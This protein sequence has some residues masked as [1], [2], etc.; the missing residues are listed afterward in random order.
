[1]AAGC[2]GGGWL[3][4]RGS[5][6]FDLLAVDGGGVL[7]DLD[8]LGDLVLGEGG[9]IVVPALPDPGVDGA[10]EFDQGGRVRADQ[11]PA[12]VDL[13]AGAVGQPGPRYDTTHVLE[14]A[15]D[16]SRVWFITGAG[17]GFGRRFTETALAHGDRV[18][19][20]L[21]QPGLL[22]DLRA[23]YHGR[24]HTLTLDIRDRDAVFAAVATAVELTGRLDIVINN[25]G[26]VLAGA[27]E[28][29]T[30]EAARQI[31][32]TNFFG[33]LWVCQAVAPHLRAQRSGHILQMSSIAGLT[34]IP[35]QGLYAAGKFAIEG[36]TES[37]AGEL[38]PFGVHIT[39]IEPGAYATGPAGPTITFAD[40]TDAYQ[41]VRSALMER[42][43]DA[44]FGDP[45]RVAEAILAVVN[46]A[47]PPRRLLLGREFDMIIDLYRSRL[48]EWTAW[49][50]TSR[51]AA[52]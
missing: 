22:D 21:R 8:G 36:M 13:I 23:R 38:E 49:E 47:D 46:S 31:M 24:L 41:P 10:D 4:C 1:M 26:Y 17:R 29:I 45:A 9:Q 19:A 50:Q 30:E 2:P 20:T 34:G 35:T 51:A 14:E 32:D 5:Q 42:F 16:T 39:L 48:E 7:D 27:V 25:A 40:F 15:M 12:A 18:V 33:T 11:D 37:L 28:E 52:G 44:E 6:P 43:A 3:A